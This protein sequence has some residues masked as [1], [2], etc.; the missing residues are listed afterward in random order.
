[1]FGVIIVENNNFDTEICDV[2][3]LAHSSA[4]RMADILLI[5]RQRHELRPKFN[6]NLL[7]DSKLI[8]R[9]RAH[10]HTHMHL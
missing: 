10:A 2:I 4:V 8:T 3:S 5:Y 6:E 1:V 9:A 7:R